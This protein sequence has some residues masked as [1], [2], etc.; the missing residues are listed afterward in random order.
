MDPYA[1]FT[2]SS[3]K[4]FAAFILENGVYPLATRRAFFQFWSFKIRLTTLPNYIKFVNPRIL[5]L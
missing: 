4:K 2:T 5:R 1:K 3:K